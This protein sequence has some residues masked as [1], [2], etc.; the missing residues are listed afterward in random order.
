MENVSGTAYF[1]ENLILDN[2]PGQTLRA[3]AGP[4][5]FIQGSG[6]WWSSNG[7]QSGISGNIQKSAQKLSETGVPK[8]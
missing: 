7:P 4:G 8:T 6:W 3:R 1:Y 2:G 5:L